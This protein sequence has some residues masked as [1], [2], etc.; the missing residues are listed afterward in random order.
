MHIA[1]SMQL[2]AWCSG[3]HNSRSNWES[4]KKELRAREHP[5]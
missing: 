5:T 3:H 2:I 4:H 1:Q